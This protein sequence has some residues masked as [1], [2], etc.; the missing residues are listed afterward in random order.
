MVQALIRVA[1]TVLFSKYNDGKEKKKK[2]KKSEDSDDSDEYLE[3]DAK[4]AMI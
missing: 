3:K 2:N 4:Q 1:Y